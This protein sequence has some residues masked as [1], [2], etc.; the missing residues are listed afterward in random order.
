M[1]PTKTSSPLY[2][3]VVDGVVYM[4]ND[5]LCKVVGMVTMTLTMKDET[6]RT[7]GNV[8]HVQA[9]KINLISLGEMVR[10]G[11][12]FK[13]H[14]MELMMGR[15][16]MVCFRGELKNGIYVLKGGICI[17][18]IGSHQQKRLARIAQTKAS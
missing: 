17:P 18:N 14:G 13:G 16:S 7:L 11:Y 4:R 12:I 3:L 8:K 9:L 1:T 5:Q 10:D 2:R 6:K 15:G